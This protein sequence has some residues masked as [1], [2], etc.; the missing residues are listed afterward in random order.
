MQFNALN[1]QPSI[2]QALDEMGYDNMTPIQ[3]QAIP[4]ILAGQDVLGLAETG[5]G[6]TGACVIPLVQG[7]QSEVN[8]IQALILVPTRSLVPVNSTAPEI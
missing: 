2:L 1:I 7:M 6:K 3:E 8:A 5:S 4:P